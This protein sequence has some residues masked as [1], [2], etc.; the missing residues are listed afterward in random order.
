MSSRN[1]HSLKR[2][3]SLDFRKFWTGET[4]S[5]LGSSFTQFALPLLVF[6][7]TGSALNLGIATAVTHLPYLL[8]GLL[9]GAWADRLDRK[10]M[11]ILVD[12]GQALIIA[13]IPVLFVL[14]ALS[15]WWI[16]VVGFVSSTLK[17]F[18]DAGRF[19]AIPSLVDQ[20]DLAR[21][22][23]RLQ[24]SFFGAT[25]VGPLLAAGLLFVV[26]VPLLLFVDAGSFLVSAGMLSL[27]LTPFNLVEKSAQKS[28]WHDI[29]EGLRYL[30]RDPVLRAIVIL[31]V[32]AN[33]F[34]AITS[35][36][37][38]LFSERQ[39]HATD[40]QFALINAAGS[41]GVIVA[42][43]LV[44][45]ILE[46]WSFTRLLLPTLAL[47][48]VSIVAL[49][50]T[51]W[52]WL[53]MPLWALFLA[54]EQFFGICTATL[55]QTIVPN[56][57]LGRVQTTTAV[58]GYSAIPLGSL[59]GGA[60]IQATGKVMPVYL[61]V[62]VV[63]VLVSVVFSFTALGHADRYLPKKQEQP[64]PGANAVAESS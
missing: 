33:F 29:A 45:R 5:N 24:A 32:P 15:I 37:L 61:G 58:V 28:I 7:L 20:Q 51:S 44:G 55:R 54:G 38:V 56:Q 9:I 47:C 43:L 16:Y 41:A 12:L 52:V 39:L 14:G 53:A 63:T 21:A 48:G 35:S 17:I 57:L 13:S 8:F 2:R 23:G 26:P 50:L 22:N 27:V 30:F 10:R 25:L 11:M 62:G 1:T 36:Q 19:A 6:K 4:I 34:S 18:F 3:T 46:R 40:S 60:V 42:A 49:S 31:L 64:Q 59:T